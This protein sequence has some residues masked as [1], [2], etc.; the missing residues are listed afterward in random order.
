MKDLHQVGIVDEITMK[1]IENLRLPNI[2]DYSPQKIMSIR[3]RYQLNQAA[4]ANVFNVCV[5]ET[6]R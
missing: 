3:K 2:G 6:S 4:L 5:I 1:N